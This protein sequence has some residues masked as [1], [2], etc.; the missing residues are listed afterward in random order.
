MFRFF[1]FG[2]TATGFYHTDHKKQNQKCISDGLQRTVDCNDHVPDFPAFEIFWGLSNNLPD[3]R[4][5]AVPRIQ[6]VLKVLNYPVITQNTF[7][8][9]G[10]YGTDCFQP[11]LCPDSEPSLSRNKRQYFLG[12]RNNDTSGQCQKSIG[13]L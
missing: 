4:Q 11:V 8:L 2:K 3:F 9:S 5:F 10:R 1:H 6:G 12:K 7:L 13:P